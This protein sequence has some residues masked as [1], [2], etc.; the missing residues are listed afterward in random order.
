MKPMALFLLAGT[1]VIAAC[2]GKDTPAPVPGREAR[3]SNITYGPH[4]RNK[5]DV[6]LPAGRTPQTP[7]VMLMHGGGWVAG[8]KEDMKGLQE[9][10][11]QHGIASVSLNYRYVDANTHYAALMEDVHKAVALCASNTAAWNIRAGRYIISGA[12]AGAHMALLYGYKYDAENRIGG[13]ISLSGPT[14]LTNLAMLNYGVSIGLGP[15]ISYITGAAYIAG[16]PL[17]PQFAEA[18]PAKQAKNIPSLLIH[19]TADNVVLYSQAEIL[20]AR[21]QEL[22]VP[23]KLVTITGEGHDLGIAKPDNLNLIIAEFI[24]WVEKYG[25]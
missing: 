1:L 3:L 21:L 17:A 8:N 14:D 11:L 25:K 12:S 2:T 5:M 16:Q 10:L 23:H 24:N 20:N 4:A 13:I 15:A 22:G 9:L 6:F 19:G 7:F 18:S